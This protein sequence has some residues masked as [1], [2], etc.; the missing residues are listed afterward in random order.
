MSEPNGQAIAPED[1][2]ELFNDHVNSGN[3]P[4]PDLVELV[5]G[6]GHLLERIFGPEQVAAGMTVILSKFYEYDEF[7]TLG[8]EW[9][10]MLDQVIEN[11][12][13][14]WP[15]G[16][17]LTWLISYAYFGFTFPAERGMDPNLP[18]EKLIR[19]VIDEAQEFLK[20]APIEQWRT[21]PYMG[22]NLK[23][24]ILLA[25]NRWALDKGQPVEPAALA[26]FGGVTEARIR[27]MMSGTDRQFTNVDGK[28]SAVE[29]LGWLTGRE[30]FFDS[31]WRDHHYPFSTDT[32]PD[33]P[34]PLFLPVAR[35][36][37]I[38]HPG[39][40]TKKGFRIGPKGDEK[41]V[42]DFDQALA[43]LQRMES[44]YWRRPNEKG[45]PGIVRGIRWERYDRNA[46]PDFISS[47]SGEPD[48]D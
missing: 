3:E 12:Y 31:I 4:G 11:A 17:K 47:T 26:V 33:F 28:V 1:R 40:A 24:V 29:A 10:K 2:I 48:D 37:S 30:S 41:V 22:T 7:T 25:E 20:V 23:E 36:G 5:R 46:L 13:S 45:R 39:L 44:P 32:K 9:E 14:N 34:Q 15:L 43:E 6:A 38:F 18:K 8:R 35:D 42:A 16:E 27:N 19:A 21:Q